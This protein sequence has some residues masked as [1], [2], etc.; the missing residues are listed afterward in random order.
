MPYNILHITFLFSSVSSESSLPLPPSTFLSP[1]LLFSCA[2]PS[3]PSPPVPT[4]PRLRGMS[5]TDLKWNWYNELPISKSKIEIINKLKLIEL[6]NE[7]LKMPNLNSFVKFRRNWKTRRMK[8]NQNE[9]QDCCIDWKGKP[10]IRTCSYR[11]LWN[12]GMF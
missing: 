9:R 10:N 1:L 3:P 4:P 11:I 8:R 7:K 5:S 2:L 6:F 12:I